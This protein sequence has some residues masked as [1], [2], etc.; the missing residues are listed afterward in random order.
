MVNGSKIAGIAT[1]G[2]LIC[3]AIVLVVVLLN[4]KDDVVDESPSVADV[5]D[6]VDDLLIEFPNAVFVQGD[7]NATSANGTRE[8]P[9]NTISAAIAASHGLNPPVLDVDVIVLAGV[10]TEPNVTLGAGSFRVLGAGPREDVVIQVSDLNS[11]INGSHASNLFERNPWVADE[12]GLEIRHVTLR[13]AAHCV[14]TRSGWGIFKNVAFENCGCDDTQR[15]NPAVSDSTDALSWWQS[16]CVDGGALRVENA[17]SVVI[18]D[19]H[20]TDSERGFQLT[21]VQSGLIRYSSATRTVQAGIHLLSNAI[22]AN[23]FV[24]DNTIRDAANN[25]IRV[26]GGLNQTISNNVVSGAWNSGIQMIGSKLTTISHN[27]IS[28]SNKVVFDGNGIASGDA[29]AG[30]AGVPYGSDPVATP[31]FVYKIVS[32]TVTDAGAGNQT[33]VYGLYVTTPGPHDIHNN[34]FSDSSIQQEIYIS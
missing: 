20:V 5:V 32:N 18:D 14:Y 30:I 8:N 7:A 25:G 11:V 28:G 15:P 4:S 16:S 23:I 1:T 12:Y 21:S 17:L 29:Y 13:R 26:V 31:S 24:H 27:G 3:G 10:V 6:R 34:D 22:G 33:K 2:G 19:C 9:Y